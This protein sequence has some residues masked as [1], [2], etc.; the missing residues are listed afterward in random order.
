MRKYQTDEAAAHELALYAINNGNLYRSQ[1]TPIIE[2][3][4][5]KKASGTYDENKAPLLWSYLAQSAAI[6]YAKEHDA[7]GVSGL[8][9]F[10]KPTRDLAAAEMAEAYQEHI[11]ERAEEIRTERANRKRWTLAEI[12]HANNEAGY[13]FF[14]RKTMTFFGDK[15]KSFAVRC[16]GERVFIERVKAGKPEFQAGAVWE[17]DPKTG[18]I[19]TTAPDVLNKDP[20]P[21]AA[22]L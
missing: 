4:A 12:K 9:T 20:K 16:I 18:H 10:D 22:A 21:Y 17:F 11:D 5:K 13:C 8:Y 14:S 15:S 19:G 6:A 3:L 1:T 2:N 7:P